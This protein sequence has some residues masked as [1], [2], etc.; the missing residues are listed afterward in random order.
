M[1]LRHAVPLALV[2]WY[3]VVPPIYRLGPMKNPK[4]EIVADTKAPL[5]KWIVIA[6]F[7]NAPECHEYPTRFQKPPSEPGA[8]LAA[9][10]WFAKAMCIAGDGPRM[11]QLKIPPAEDLTVP[12]HKGKATNEK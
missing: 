8:S 9:G 7:N 6:R 12:S 3:F 2:F 4:T 5:S 10:Y 1:N 11:S